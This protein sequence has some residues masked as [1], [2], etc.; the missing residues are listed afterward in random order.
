MAT[1]KELSQY[2]GYSIATI[3]RVLSGDPTMSASP[4]TR[5]RILKAAG[6]L[7]YPTTKSKRGRNVKYL[8]R[9]GVAEMLSL[10]E[11]LA[12]PYYLYL[13]NY[14]EQI[15]REQRIETAPLLSSPEGFQRLDSSPLQGII[16]IG[17]F[18]PQQTQAL[19]QQCPNLVFLDS[20]PDE[21]HHDS[22]V[23]NYRLGVLQAIG[24]L[25][26]LGHQKI[27]FIGPYRKL[28]DQK[29]PAP[30]VRRQIFVEDRLAKGRYFQEYILETPMNAS[31]AYEAV[32]QFLERGGDLP[33]AF[34]TAN[35]EIAI[36]SI[37]ALR[38]SGLDIPRDVSVVSFNDTALS[39]L[40]DPPLTSISTHVS[41]LAATAVKLVKE[42]ARTSSHPPQRDMPQKVVIPPTLA[43]RNSTAPPRP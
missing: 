33:T 13:K 11:Q 10:E 39:E 42:R 1:L 27:G 6:E 38:R 15:C 12:D 26:A 18:H 8:L 37:R 21:L 14:V 31:A 24:H 22:V 23:L 36:G 9:I 40:M 7:S 3:S 32:T 35:E 25:E 43:V 4:E 28:D 30:E 2:T 29:R 19:E 17:I 41:Y 16:A 20:S 34:I 5:Q